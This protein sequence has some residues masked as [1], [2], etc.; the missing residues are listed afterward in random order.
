[1]KKT[2]YRSLFCLLLLTA[3]LILSAIFNPVGNVEAESVA[4]ASNPQ[5]EIIARIYT[6][7]NIPSPYPTMLLFHGV[8][9]SKEMMVPLAVELARNGMA[10]IA[11][12][13]GGYG[14]SYP[15]KVGEKSLENLQAT[16][17]ADAK[18]VLAYV[19]SQPEKFDLNRIGVL[20]HSMGGA[21][22]LALGKRDPEL[23]STIV[24]GMAG[25]A[26]TTSPANL[27]LGAGA[28]EQINPPS[29]L[30][31]TLREATATDN[32]DCIN[33][34]KVCGDFDD[35]SA[36]KLVISPTS[37]HI[38][39]PFNQGLIT[40]AV[41]WARR[42]LPVARPG[43]FSDSD[44]A[45][46]ERQRVDAPA[47]P[48]VTP[49]FLFSL[50]LTFFGG[51]AS[52]VS[53]FMG[54]H[55]SGMAPLPYSLWRRIVTWLLGILMAT[56]LLMA[57]SG[58]APTRSASNTLL[59]CYVLQLFGNYGLRQ[60]QQFVGRLRVGCLYAC[61]LI[62][63]FLLP[64]LLCGIGEIWRSPSYLLSLPLFLLIWPLFAF[65]NYAI[66]AKLL[67]I[68]AYTLELQVSWL[69]VLL[70]LVELFA[71]GL[72]LTVLG[73]G[74]VRG[75]KWLRRSWRFTGVGILTLPHKALIGTLAGVLVVVW[76][77]R[78][79]DGLVAVVA[80]KGWLA[81]RMAGLF[82]LLPVAVMVLGVRWRRF[83]RLEEK[84]HRDG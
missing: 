54:P 37:D 8:N 35:G 28:Y 40:E 66:S 74:V 65:Y 49:W 72:T 14:E 1:M 33:G 57:N 41:E 68:P 19:R 44:V 59:F 67:L 50:V 58:L 2:R 71:P 75:V 38:I 11:F 27:L 70:V 32:P 36:R 61:L 64:A 12:D 39:E 25:S 78:F 51:V 13:F 60:P 5:Q 16:T 63:A 10:A 55:Y 22:A 29:E 62:V 30:R 17:L 15:L 56:I 81:L 7:T 20:G 84:L 77:W 43:K 26:T 46:A 76:Y 21:T 80:S 47:Q 53:I 69:F 23:R 82:L 6:P 83:K 3:G 42:S 48:P 79:A 4:I 34:K 9:N 52:G 45:N 31:S 24:L 18:T 73:R